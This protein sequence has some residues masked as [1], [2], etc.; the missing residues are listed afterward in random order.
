MGNKITVILY[1][2]ASVLFYMVSASKFFNSGFYICC[3]LAVFRLCL[4]L[5]WGKCPKQA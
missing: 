3:S 1:Y 5:F 4:P 2:I